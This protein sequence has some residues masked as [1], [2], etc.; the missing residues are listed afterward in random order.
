MFGKESVL[1]VLRYVSGC[2]HV[3]VQDVFRVED[4]F[5]CQEI[6]IYRTPFAFHIGRLIASHAMLC[7]YRAAVPEGGC[8]AF[9]RN[10]LYCSFPVAAFDCGTQVKVAFARVTED[11][12]FHI[13]LD[14]DFLQIGNECGQMFDR[15]AYVLD[16]RYDMF[17]LLLDYIQKILANPPQCFLFFAVVFDNII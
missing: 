2:K 7:R 5:Y 10:F 8:V 16:K 3:R 13:I 12:E 1:H 4:F 9:A 11:N 15:H 14:K 6:R 17:F